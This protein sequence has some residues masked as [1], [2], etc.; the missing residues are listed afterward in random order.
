MADSLYRSHS[1][2]TSSNN[3][4]TVTSGTLTIWEDNPVSP[5]D[6]GDTFQPVPNGPE[7][8]VKRVSI[9]DNVIGLNAGKP[10][11]QWQI[12]IEGSDEDDS[13]SSSADDGERHTF[14]IE[15]DGSDT[16]HSGTVSKSL[17]RET[18]PTT[19]SVGDSIRLPGVGSLKCTK[20]TGSDD[21]NDSGNRVWNITYECSDTENSSSSGTE[22]LPE[23]RY[24]FTIDS[25]NS[26]S[27][28]VVNE[29][30][31]PALTLSVGSK[32]TIPG[33]G[34]VTCT[35]ISGSDDYTDSGTHRWTVTYEGSDST[36]STSIDDNV[37]YTFSVEDTARSGTKQVTL[38]GDSPSFA[39]SVG[40]S[41]SI[42]GV[43][44][45]TCT[46]ASGSDDY[47]DDGR[48]RWT[49][50]YEGEYS[51]ASSTETLPETKYTLAIEKD[52]DGISQLSGSMAVTN[53]GDSPALNID[54]GNSFYVPGI[55][56]IKCT[57][58]S[59]SDS[60]S[61][62][63]THLW[64]MTYEGQIVGSSGSSGGE[65]GGEGVSGVVG[66]NKYSFSVVKNSDGTTSKSGSIE[67]SN[68][69]E[70]PASSY[71]IDERIN[72]FP[73]ISLDDNEKFKVVKISGSD[74]YTDD[75]KR[76]WT[77]VYELSNASSDEASYSFSI[78]CN[79]N[80]FC[81]YSGTK[82][83]SLEEKNGQAP[84]L[85]VSIGDELMFPIISSIQGVGKLKCT[86]IS[87]SKQDTGNWTVTVECSKVVLSD[88]KATYSYS[89]D[90]D[91]NE[92][93]V[94]SGSKQ[95]IY[96]VDTQ[97]TASLDSISEKVGQDFKIPFI[98]KV[99]CT[100]IS[101]SD[102]GSG[103]W[104]ITATGVRVGEESPENKYTLPE[105]E[106]STTYEIN[107]GTVRTVDGEFIAL[108]RSETPITRK[109][110]TKYEEINSTSSTS[111]TS[112]TL[113][114]LK[115]GDIYENGLI[116]SISVTKE[117]IK[118]NNVVITSY[119][120]YTIEVEA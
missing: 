62:N 88:E 118:N 14:S 100:D 29:G 74:D 55:G 91:E 64:T 25:E 86:K 63:G 101:S 84:E 92:N 102:D 38:Y 26:G 111:S 83:Y 1:L 114:D 77:V 47:L 39:H 66:H 35:K 56:N 15:Q 41:F 50:T 34:E 24:S 120:K 119:N 105:S 10:V 95:Y 93:T 11:R 80:G 59:G 2:E 65:G 45:V 99:K 113:S 52:N 17:E 13:S 44:T 20:I 9:N 79:N 116:T 90:Y 22:A 70:T 108:R 19:I 57:K 89:I 69:N 115:P 61:D 12:S 4:E 72:K 82:Q 21:F 49:I 109:T 98:G 40:D 31:T 103:T 75:D 97:H 51:S 6:V 60:Y 112:S 5:L 8:T 58:V 110:I 43:G 7:L 46:K 16:V 87:S 32:F 107:G 85:D 42:P 27:M 71:A 3:G 68:I 117:T 48:H 53:S 106:T 23:T 104:T 33:V 28:Q 76:K 37:K 54:V 78:D 36:S 94:Y 73:G 18:P 67:Q 96:I 81:Q 30:A